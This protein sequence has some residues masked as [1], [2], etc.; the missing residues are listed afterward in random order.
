MAIKEINTEGVGRL[1][2]QRF[3]ESYKILKS[4]GKAEIESDAV[5]CRIIYNNILML[6]LI[7]FDFKIKDIIRVVLDNIYAYF[8]YIEIIVPKKYNPGSLDV[9]SEISR[10]QVVGYA[11]L[12]MDHGSFIV[13]PKEG[14]DKIRA[15]FN[16]LFGKGLLKSNEK[17]NLF[18]NNYL[19]QGDKAAF[20]RFA[21][22]ETKK[23]MLKLKNFNLFV[24]EDI[25][26]AGMIEDFKVENVIALSNFFKIIQS[27]LG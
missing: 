6:K 1:T 5:I 8:V 14:E 12:N 7:G 23:E 26:I 4:T 27:Q 17:D 18:Y 9:T 13:R 2:A 15:S 11:K 25:L 16:K 21:S 3:I 22:A 10:Y 19:I 20:E 24:N